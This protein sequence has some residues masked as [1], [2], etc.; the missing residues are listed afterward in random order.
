M[1]GLA[2]H[3]LTKARRAAALAELLGKLR[4]LGEGEPNTII[5]RRSGYRKPYHRGVHHYYGR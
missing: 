5:W 2:P 4:D 1:R 3:R